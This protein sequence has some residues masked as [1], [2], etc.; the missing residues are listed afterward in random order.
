MS[1]KR[2]ERDNDEKRNGDNPSCWPPAN[3]LCHRL[4]WG[5][6]SQIS[7]RG[8]YHAVLTK[9]DNGCVLC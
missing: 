2:G 7:D 3:L 1:D 6:Q 5:G 8:S 4:A 9:V